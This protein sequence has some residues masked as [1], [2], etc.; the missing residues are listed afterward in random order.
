MWDHS[1]E[2]GSDL[3]S[4]LRVP[5]GCIVSPKIKS[6]GGTCEL[7]D[8]GSAQLGGDF[9]VRGFVASVPVDGSAGSTPPGVEVVVVSAPE[10]VRL[11]SPNVSCL[12][13]VMICEVAILYCACVKVDTISNMQGMYEHLVYQNGPSPLLMVRSAMV[14][15]YT[16]SPTS[17]QPIVTASLSLRTASQPSCNG[18][19]WSTFRYSS[20]QPLWNCFFPS[21]TFK[22]L[23]P[24]PQCHHR[25]LGLCASG[26]QGGPQAVCRPLSR[27]TA[28]P[29]S[30]A[31]HSCI[32][33]CNQIDADENASFCI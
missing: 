28:P 2:G 19:F 33:F 11:P 21:Y 8:F 4:V 20:R 6:N 22:A 15:A 3:D 1:E 30:S 18:R 13:F 7:G 31:L 17:G 9:Y 32:Y 12:Y 29:P 16:R 25:R 27:P 24:Q 10:P 26:A 23:T 14:R 5:Q